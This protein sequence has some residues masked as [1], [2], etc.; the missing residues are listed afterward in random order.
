[1]PTNCW[2]LTG[3]RC[4]R[5]GAKILTQKFSPARETLEESDETDITELTPS[6]PHIS[7]T[8]LAAPPLRSKQPPPAPPASPPPSPNHFLQHTSCRR[9][10]PM[11]L[12][13]GAVSIADAVVL[14]LTSSRYCSGRVC[15]Q[16]SSN[17]AGSAR[18]RL[19]STTEQ[20]Q[21]RTERDLRSAS[22]MP[23]FL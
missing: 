8:R 12:S 15:P 20:Q 4:G 7:S 14:W 5:G 6:S 21:R 19:R 2:S 22:C 18:W 16:P 3:P 11:D 13:N 9:L 23:R 1:M 17:S 10:Q